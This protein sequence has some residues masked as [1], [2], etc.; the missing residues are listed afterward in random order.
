MRK[1]L[2]VPSLSRLSTQGGKTGREGTAT[3]VHTQGSQTRRASGDRALWCEEPWPHSPACH[4]VPA[5]SHPG[6]WAVPPRSQQ[7]ALS[8]GSP[9]QLSNLRCT[10]EVPAANFSVSGPGA[11]RPRLKKACSP[12]EVLSPPPGDAESRAAGPG[13]APYMLGGLRQV[14]LLP[15][16]STA[17]S[18]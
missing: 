8:P 12:L 17:A 15:L 3:H 9:E 1:H 6:F 16:L 2:P 10:L 4:P 11:G 13:S 18:W 7:D 5:K 14:A